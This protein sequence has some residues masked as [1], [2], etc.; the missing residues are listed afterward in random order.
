MWP[1][2]KKRG[3]TPEASGSDEKPET[4]APQVQENSGAADG[5][6]QQKIAHF[7]AEITK[8]KGVLDSM[9]EMRKSSQERFSTMN[10][11]IGEIRGELMDAK[12]N[13]SMI[14][15][16]AIK[17]ADLVE[18]VHPDKLL[19]QVQKE[20]G[21]I[22]GLRGMLE[23]KDEIIKNVRDQLKELKQQMKLFRGIEQVIKLNEEV[24]DELMNMKKIAASVQQ[25]ADKVDNIFVESQ[26][27]YQEFSRF[28]DQID[29][30][31]DKISQLTS[32]TDGLE[33]TQKSFVK[34]RDFEKR[35]AQ[36]E[37]FDKKMKKVLKN[38]EKYYKG[39]EDKF[40]ELEGG[41]K[42]TFDSRME[43][44]QKI[45]EAFIKLLE[46][47]PVFAKG[48]SL[49]EFLNKEM[50][51]DEQEGAVD[52]IEDSSNEDTSPED[53]GSADD[54]DAADDNDSP[55]ESDSGEESDSPEEK[56]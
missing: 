39:M 40:K 36:I 20:D 41:L 46:E 13:M 34:K 32:R 28:Q 35:L 6:T 2:S 33:S 31:N 19:I 7:D 30:A 10:E 51:D 53:D 42:G 38:S 5:K 11:Q 14:E 1:F 54:S 55:K 22:E 37:R 24:K 9:Q 26:K 3:E 21:K 29:T 16:K 15:V 47:N 52:S 25:H 27:T 43:R 23:A 18:S 8:I 49:Q 17:A 44:A 56:S 4:T 48:L 50:G 12:K 45:S